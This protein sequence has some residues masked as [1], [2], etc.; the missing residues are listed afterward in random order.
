[1]QGNKRAKPKWQRQS[2]CS[3]VILI[4]WKKKL[5]KHNKYSKLKQY[6]LMRNLGWTQAR[7]QN[8]RVFIETFWPHK[9]T[10][11]KKKKQIE[12]LAMTNVEQCIYNNAELITSRQT[13][14]FTLTIFSA[15]GRRNR[16]IHNRSIAISFVRSSLFWRLSFDIVFTVNTVNL[17]KIVQNVLLFTTVLVSKPCLCVCYFSLGFQFSK[18]NSQN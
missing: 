5:T 11:N 8:K 3:Y 12:Q 9:H 4:K 16:T 7:K 6:F 13:Q 17:P 18:H 1:M 15:K 14:K 2:K 10:G